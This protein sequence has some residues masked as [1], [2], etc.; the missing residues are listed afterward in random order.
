VCD[1]KTMQH[2][3]TIVFMSFDDEIIVT[4]SNLATWHEQT[5]SLSPF[6]PHEWQEQIELA[7]IS[8]V[9]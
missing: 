1:D 9:G 2:L 8:L 5:L 4:M 3:M 6:N 7:W